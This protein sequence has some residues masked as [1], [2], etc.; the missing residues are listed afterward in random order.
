MP[1]TIS[2]TRGGTAT[3][4]VTVSNGQTPN[5][6]I[7]R[8]FRLTVPAPATLTSTQSPAG[9]V[10]FSVFPNPA[11]AGVF[12][13]MSATPGP[14]EVTILDLSGRVLLTRQLVFGPRPMPLTL[15]P[16]ARAGVYLV[17]VRTSGGL[18]TRRLAVVE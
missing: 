5:G 9:N 1:Y 8:S 7:T 2:A 13:L 11:P 15:P 4:S 6:S 16:A 18:A 17:R 10:V 3:I 14:A 12:Q